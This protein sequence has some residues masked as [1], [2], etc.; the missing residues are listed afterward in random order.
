VLGYLPEVGFGPE[1]VLPG[2]G[3][4]GWEVPPVAGL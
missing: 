3:E 4:R 2:G 1:R